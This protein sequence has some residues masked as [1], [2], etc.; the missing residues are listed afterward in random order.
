MIFWFS[1]TGNSLYAAQK[2]AAAQGEQLISVAAEFDKPDNPFTYRFQE[3][4]L[5]GFV[6]PVYAWAPPA[7]VRRFIKQ[8]K[9]EGRPF[10]F[11]VSTCGSDEGRATTVVEKALEAKGLKLGCALTLQMPSNYII[12]GDI[13]SPEDERRILAAAEEKLDT[14]NELLAER[15]TG[16]FELIPGKMPALLTGLVNPLFD[17]FAKSTGRFY[18]TDACNSCGLCERIC[19]VHT[20]SVTDK[21]AWGK[22]CTQC[23]ACINRCPRR[24]IEYGQ[25]TAKRGRYVHPCL[26]QPGQQ[27]E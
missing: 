11:S 9:I 17:A 26:K 15:R 7:I 16:I 23:L 19:P 8:M 3:G 18:A 21:P 4:E 27:D 14:F 6:W 2:I 22:E 20:I 13:C 24:A 12:G 1:G 5:L 25:A 10:A